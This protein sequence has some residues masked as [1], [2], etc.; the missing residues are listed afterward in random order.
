M[1]PLGARSTG[2]TAHPSNPSRLYAVT[3][4]DS[5]PL[6]ILEVDVAGSAARVI[7]QINVNT[8]GFEGL[9]IEGIV[10]KPNG[11]F[12]LASEG[13]AGNNPPNVLLEVDANGL[14]LRS[15]PL[16][17]VIANRVEKKALRALRSKSRHPVRVFTLPSRRRS[18]VIPRTSPGLAQ[19]T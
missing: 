11:G 9:D 15:L 4:E 13:K 6:R 19:L 14:L 1:G 2:L 7:R 10:A 16:P 12:W 3:D 17:E 18:P 5:P 8:P